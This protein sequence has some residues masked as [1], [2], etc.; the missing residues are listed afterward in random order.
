MHRPAR[1]KGYH[2]HIY[3]P[4]TAP[5]LNDEVINGAEKLFDEAE[6]LA[7]DDA[8]RFRVR[9]ARLPIWYVQLATNRVTGD[10]RT[11]LLNRFLSVA[12]KAGITSISES[13][14]LEDWAKRMGAE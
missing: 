6:R 4:P 13:R 2:A 5:Y 10:A 8:T 1:E 9:V 7:D 3:D 12:R 11:S 14:S